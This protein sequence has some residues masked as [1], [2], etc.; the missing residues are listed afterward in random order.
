MND[1]A[2][3]AKLKRPISLATLLPAKE[4]A[5]VYTVIHSD[6]GGKNWASAGS[7]GK[8][9]Q[10]VRFARWPG[11]Y[12]Y[13]T[14]CIA[15][16]AANPNTIALGT[17]TGPLIGR[18]TLDAFVWEDHG[19][20][21]TPASKGNPHIHGDI[22]GLLFDPNDPSG[23]TL[24]VCGDR[25][26]VVTKDLY[27]TFSSLLNLNLSNLQFQSYPASPYA[28]PFAS[29]FPGASGVSPDMAGLAAGP[30]QDNGSCSLWPVNRRLGSE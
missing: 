13:A 4:A 3:K 10:S 12:Q 29:A 7:H 18:R 27:Q 15:V 23:K 1:L 9:D 16:S 21:D 11:F 20:E 30:L 8:V 28:P 5:A 26:A 2:A 25:G 22:H 17:R 19:N 24:Y 14:W 6:N